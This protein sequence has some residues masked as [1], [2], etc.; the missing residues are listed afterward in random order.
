M[1]KFNKKSISNFSLPPMT[2]FIKRLRNIYTYINSLLKTQFS[3][4]LS[5]IVPEKSSKPSA[6]QMEFQDKTFLTL[7]WRK[8][9][10]I[11]RRTI[12]LPKAFLNPQNKNWAFFELS[13]PF[14]SFN[15]VFLT[16]KCKT[17]DLK[18]AA[19]CDSQMEWQLLPRVLY[20]QQPCFFNQSEC[21][22]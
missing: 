14:V 11:S 5:K 3:W 8:H 2:K 15:A 17:L 12:S 7:L 19:W 10:W 21:A 22:L 1:V 13:L 18:P 16:L 20:S 9:R 4:A 6:A